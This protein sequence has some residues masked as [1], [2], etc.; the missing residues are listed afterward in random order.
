MSSTMIRVV[1]KWLIKQLCFHPQSHWLNVSTKVS[2]LPK[3][4]GYSILLEDA[5]N[6]FF[7]TGE[8]NTVGY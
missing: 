3:V 5:L 4:M 6:W 2:A 1:E 8:V 7:L